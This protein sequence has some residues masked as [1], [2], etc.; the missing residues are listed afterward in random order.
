[1]SPTKNKLP[2]SKAFFY[3]ALSTLIFSGVPAFIWNSY[4]FR[5]KERAKN[6]KYIITE[7]AQTGPVK[8]ALKSEHLEEI[9]GLSINNS[10]NIFTFDLKEAEDRLINSGV[11]K[12][13]SVSIEE[14]STVLVEYSAREPVA[15]VADYTNLVMD[16]EGAL[17]PLVP[18]YTPKLLPKIYFGI[19]IEP[20]AYGKLEDE[21]LKVAQNILSFF[22]KLNLSSQT[23]QNIDVSNLRADSVGKQ[24]VIV[25]LTEELGRKNY[26]RYLRLTCD[27]Y[28]EEIEHYLSLKQ[29]SMPDDLI[30]DL[31][32]LPCAYITPV[33]EA[34]SS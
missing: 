4:C 14:P 7:L 24:E 13:A 27:N 34:S 3:I 20:I 33:S 18:Y 30:I 23:I 10:Q 31:R 19:K 21:K 5:Q 28:L 1:M 11:I 2:L 9:L 17:F 26:T 12:K 29:M 6:P 15:Y 22:E 16:S 32:L 25:V 8:E